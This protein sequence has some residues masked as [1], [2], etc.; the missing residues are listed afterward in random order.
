[1]TN[2]SH[3]LGRQ[4]AQVS[5]SHATSPPS[6]RSCN[7][8]EE[9]VLLQM[10]GVDGF[11]LPS[12]SCCVQCQ[13]G[14]RC[15]AADAVLMDYRC[16][17]ICTVSACVRVCVHVCGE[18]GQ[19]AFCGQ[20]DK[21]QMKIGFQFGKEHKRQQFTPPITP[22]RENPVFGGNC[23]YKKQ[24]TF[25]NVLTPDWSDS[26]RLGG[27]CIYFLFILLWTKQYTAQCRRK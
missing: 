24:K 9:G 6:C 3:A 25:S 4:R 17:D 7:K 21:K 12:R 23:N 20:P 1:M 8:S 16:L 26:S 15:A 10:G 5:Q 13:H 11:S 19:R 18:R 27:Y 22:K 2:G 14:R